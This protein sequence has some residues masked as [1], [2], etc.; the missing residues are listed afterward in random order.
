MFEDVEYDPSLPIE[1]EVWDGDNNYAGKW[2]VKG[3]NEFFYDAQGNVVEVRPIPEVVVEEQLIGLDLG[4]EPKP[5][6]VV[7]HKRDWL[8]T[9]LAVIVTILIMIIIL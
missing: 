6:V 1:N 9:T 5:E 3:D 7:V 8:T 2:V 4:P